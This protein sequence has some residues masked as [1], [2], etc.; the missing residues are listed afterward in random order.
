M[1]RRQLPVGKKPNQHLDRLTLGSHGS[2]YNSKAGSFN[3]VRAQV[4]LPISLLQEASH[5]LGSP[6]TVMEHPMRC[7]R[8]IYFELSVLI[9]LLAVCLWDI[10]AFAETRIALVVGNSSYQNIPR[11]SNPTN[12]ARLMADTLSALGFTLVGGSAQLDLDKTTFDNT[13]RTFGS[14]LQGANVALS[15]MQ[16]TVCR[17]AEPTILFRSRAEEGCAPQTVDWLK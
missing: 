3:S 14:Q 13:I 8:L 4:A 16:A 17:C 9:A 1:R 2:S 11:L 12:D 5:G 15:T 6:H 10:P 7:R